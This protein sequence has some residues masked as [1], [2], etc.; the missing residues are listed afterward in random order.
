[1]FWA[2]ASVV[3][4]CGA[5]FVVSL[6]LNLVVGTT[7]RTGIDTRSASASPTYPPFAGVVQTETPEVATP[8]YSPI[9][10][11]TPAQP[12]A[13]STEPAAPPTASL[14]AIS[15]ATIEATASPTAAVAVNPTVQGLV[16]AKVV[17]VVDGDTLDVKIGGQTSRVRIIGVNAPEVSGTVMCYGAEA[18]IKTRQLVDSVGGEV[19]LE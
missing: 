13:S 14:T 16:P 17:R 19:L 18:T 15:T 2:L 11:S 12:Q 6:L 7:P 4:L 9:L 1:M 3:T 10:T 8:G 5:I